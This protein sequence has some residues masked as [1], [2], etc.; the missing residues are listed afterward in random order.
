MSRCQAAD[1]S[2]LP[3]CTEIRFED[4]GS[5]GRL[6][7][8]PRARARQDR[9]DKQIA[10]SRQE[11]VALMAGTHSQVVVIHR[12]LQHSHRGVTAFRRSLTI[13]R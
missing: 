6:A 5:T 2:F 4:D 3:A 12:Y 13:H 11:R 8:S 7:A 10:Y 9:Q 1:D